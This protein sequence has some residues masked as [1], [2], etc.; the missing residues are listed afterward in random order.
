M[1]FTAQDLATLER[2]IASGV[3]QVKY[4]DRVITYQDMGAM[5]T[6]R[7][8]MA[9]ELGISLGPADGGKRRVFRMYQKG[10]GY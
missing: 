5:R 9:R 3:Q 1:A 8:E 6:A 10:N 2:A 7:A 4:A